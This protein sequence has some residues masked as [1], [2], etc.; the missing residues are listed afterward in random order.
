VYFSEDIDGFHY[1][2]M[3]PLRSAGR[4]NGFMWQR[5]PV[6][7]GG[8]EHIDAGE[9]PKTVRRQAYRIFAKRE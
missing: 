3:R 1:V 5:V 2:A 6:I 7:E 8:F 9:V 4:V